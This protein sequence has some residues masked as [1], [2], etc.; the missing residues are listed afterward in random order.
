MDTELQ[1]FFVTFTTEGLDKVQ[2]DIANLSDKLDEVTSG[3][4]KSG[5]GL[6]KISGSLGGFIGKLGL[7][8]TA[9][10]LA[11]AA[12]KNA[13]TVGNDALGLK[14]LAEYAGVSAEKL[15]Q[16]GIM[17]K[18]YGGD[19]K[20]AGQDYIKINTALGEL[21][22]RGNLSE[23]MRDVL[24]RYAQYGLRFSPDMSADDVLANL[25]SVFN[26]L[27]ARGD[28]WGIQQIQS[29]YGISQ[30]TALLLM[31]SM[32]QLRE[33]AARAR[34]QLVLSS[35]ETQKN[36]EAL[37]EA[38]QE[39][40][41]TWDK[42]SAQLIPIITDVVRLLSPVVSA[43]KE[44]IDLVKG[45]IKVLTGDIR[46]KDL[47]ESIKKGDGPLG[48]AA[49][50]GEEIGKGLANARRK[51]DASKSARNISSGN[52]TLGDIA[53]VKGWLQD[54]GG[55]VYTPDEIKRMNDALDAAAAELFR[56]NTPLNSISNTTNNTQTEKITR[57]ELVTPNGTAFY[58]VNENGTATRTGGDM[59][60]QLMPQ[61]LTIGNR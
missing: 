28:N 39:L 26:K 42:L 35:K 45:I 37:Q 34:G 10:A 8:T 5:S 30:P 41:A 22:N 4:N 49:N 21:R 48:W 16:M 6:N 23:S 12:I 38:K 61:I 3:I 57:I 15:E 50:K 11:A 32:D 25:Q 53:Q 17:M 2:Q 44:F 58:D 36:A 20:N 7:A 60:S 1:N 56:T 31:Q 27:K 59:S 18:K 24:A 47:W 54:G 46:W 40:K 14:N 55:N 19:W 29:A 13:F 9:A 52:Y 43:V 51:Q 33:E